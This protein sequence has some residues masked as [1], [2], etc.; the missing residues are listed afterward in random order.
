MSMDGGKQL[1]DWHPGPQERPERFALHRLGP[2]L[3]DF[4]RQK[5]KDFPFLPPKGE[6][7]R[8]GSV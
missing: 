4:S 7:E 3:T 2:Q 5:T 8:P 6:E 1:A